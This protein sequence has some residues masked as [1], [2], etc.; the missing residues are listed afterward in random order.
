LNR[1]ILRVIACDE[2]EA[3]AQGRPSDDLSG[4]ARRARA[5]AIRSSIAQQRRSKTLRRPSGDFGSSFP[6]INSQASIA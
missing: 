3:F 1:R 2:R 4:V 6:N 5:E